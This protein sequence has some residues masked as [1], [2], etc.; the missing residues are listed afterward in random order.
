MPAWWKTNTHTKSGL[1]VSLFFLKDK[2]IKLMKCG[3]NTLSKQLFTE[4][5][6][7]IN[8]P[9]E[10]ITMMSID[11]FNPFCDT[12]ASFNLFFSCTSQIYGVIIS[13]DISS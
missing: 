11:L 13:E 1:T 6:F 5:L 12:Q 7:Q 3:T 10:R 9:T 8:N 4:T 2:Q